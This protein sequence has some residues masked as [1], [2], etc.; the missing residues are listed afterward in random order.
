MSQTRMEGYTSDIPYTSC[1]YRE[2]EPEFINYSAVMYGLQPIDLENGF[3]H[4]D[5]GCGRGL[6][7]LIMAANYPQG[8]FWAT[9]YS[10]LHIEQAQKIAD[11][12]G[13]T[14]IHFLELSFQQL[15]EDPTLLPPCDFITLHGIYTW[16]NDE[17]RQ[18]VADIL[19]QNLKPGGFVYNS[20]NAMPG[21][22][23]ITPLQTALNELNHVLDGPSTERFAI[24][25]DFINHFRQLNPRYFTLNQ[26]TLNARLDT[27]EKS[28][29]INYLVHEYI[30]DGWKPFH[31][32]EVARHMATAELDYAGQVS[33]AESYAHGHMSPDIQQAINLFTSTELQQL[34]KDMAYNTGFRM[35]LYTK[36]AQRL[37]TEQQLAW[38]ETKQWKLVP[39]HVDNFEFRLS[40]GL[41]EGTHDAYHTVV[42]ALKPAP[43]SFQE[44]CETTQL[45]TAM[46]AQILAFL[47]HA[48][49][50][51]ISEQ[52]SPQGAQLNRQIAAQPF[53]AQHNFVSAPAIR[54]GI[55]LS[56]LDFS[57]L[58]QYFDAP[59]DTVLPDKL[60]LALP[61]RM[62]KLELDLH[63]AEG[64]FSGATM[65][66]KLLAMATAWQQ[67]TRP[68]WEKL[69][70]I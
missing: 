4:C 34:F 9:D 13:L 62:D 26:Q 33:P 3:T 5:L 69:G 70:I 12:A 67:N 36:K 52:P 68:V 49:I 22:A 37:D 66:E 63:I 46:L 55:L 44:L 23:A 45:N 11:Q 42:D 21:W 35:D 57:I 25:R 6:T 20:Y 51:A 54:A 10:P 1:Y 14:N 40:V 8:E 32:H 31:F 24:S 48:D 47:F 64:G 43:T 59:D 16:V 53:S 27:I 39:A 18:H 60:A 17:N 56:P 58:Q 15:A 61:K 28:T 29:D 2:L 19:Q 30:H 41:I 38:L 65:D 7:S 50:V